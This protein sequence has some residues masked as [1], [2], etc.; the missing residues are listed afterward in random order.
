MFKLNK[1]EIQN[2]EGNHVQLFS[3]KLGKVERE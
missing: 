1:G 3:T 2:Y